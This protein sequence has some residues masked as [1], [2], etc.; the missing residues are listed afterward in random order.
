MTFELERLPPPGSR[1][2]AAL[3]DRLD[4]CDVARDLEA[5]AVTLPADQRAVIYRAQRLLS[6][7]GA[8]L[9]TLAVTLRGSGTV[10]ELLR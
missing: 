1:E 4:L 7:Q 6:R 2:E 9:T 10:G 8:T 5:L 3:L